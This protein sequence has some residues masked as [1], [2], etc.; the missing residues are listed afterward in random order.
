VKFYAG[1]ARFL[2]KGLNKDVSDSRSFALIVL[3]PR[4]LKV[5]V[6]VLSINCFL[7]SFVMFISPSFHLSFYFD[8]VNLELFFLNLGFISLNLL[9]H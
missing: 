9:F 3:V 2:I 4:F 5:V 7:S 1:F 8:S 6:R